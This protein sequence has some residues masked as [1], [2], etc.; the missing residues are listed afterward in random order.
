MATPDPEHLFKQAEKLVQPPPAGPPLQVDVRRAVSAAYYAVFHALLTAAA[1]EFVG[2][3]KH[4]DAEYVLAYRSINHAALRKLCD[5]LK[6]ASP[7]LRLAQHAPP[8]GFG[9]DIQALAVAVIDLQEKRHSADYDPSMRVRTADALLA[10]RTG[11]R[12][13][14]RF[15]AA[16]PE[17]RKRFL[18]LLL[19]SPR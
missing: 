9:A 10:I 15:D 17:V 4:A 14:A 12:A 1:D 16:A 8:N 6:S 13:L 19:F 3:T 5:G 11:R 7:P 2:K 18:A